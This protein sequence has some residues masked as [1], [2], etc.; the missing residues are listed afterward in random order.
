MMTLWIDEKNSANS[1]PD[2]VLESLDLG[3]QLLPHELGDLFVLDGLILGSV[4]GC[5]M[6]YPYSLDVER[7]SEQFWSLADEAMELDDAD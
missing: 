1:I 3:I 4:M 5:R 6:I 2:I 7:Y